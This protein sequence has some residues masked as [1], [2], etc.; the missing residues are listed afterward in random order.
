MTLLPSLMS[1]HFI[2]TYDIDPGAVLIRGMNSTV[3]LE[4]VTSSFRALEG[5]RSTFVVLNETHHWIR[6]NNGDKMYETIDGNVTKKDSRYLAITNAYLPGED[7]VAEKI[8]EAFNK[9]LEGRSVDPGVLYDSLEAK[10]EAPLKGK[11][12]PHVLRGVRGDA[13]WLRISTIIQSIAN[14]T[15]SPSRSRRMWLNQV[16]AEEDA[17]FGPEQW[18]KLERPDAM[19]SPGDEIVLGFDGGKTDDATALVAIRVKDFLAVPLIIEEKPDGPDGDGWEVDKAKVESEIHDAFRIYKVVGFYADIALWEPNIAAWSAAYGDG[20][21]VKSDGRN[22]IAWDMRQSLKRVTLANE[23]LMQRIFDGKL[24][25]DGDLTLRRH[26]LNARRRSNNYGISFGKEGRESPRKV[27]GYAA[28]LLANEAMTD[29]LTRG[30]KD[31]KPLTGNG[32][33]L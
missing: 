18:Q 23:K 22:A 30:K 3:R 33:F 20:L 10:P 26:V 16:V 2:S 5:G 32:W 8:R 25:H 12:L 29:Y 21:L 13:K 1:D 7:S 15:M 31:K 24:I 28:L 11:L 17:L 4:A 9:I 19:L 27:D 14:T 6:G